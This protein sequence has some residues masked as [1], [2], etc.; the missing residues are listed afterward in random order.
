MGRKVGQTT[1]KRLSPLLHNL[2][3]KGDAG[4]DKITT[5]RKYSM[6]KGCKRKSFHFI[7]KDIPY[8]II[9][10]YFSL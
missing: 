7:D 4:N 5:F 3:L 6:I 10:F 1:A 9:H 8:L 2:N